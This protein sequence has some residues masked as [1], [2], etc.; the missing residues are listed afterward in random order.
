MRRAETPETLASEK[1]L[2]GAQIKAAVDLL[3]GVTAGTVAELNAIELLTSLGIASDRAKAMAAA[4]K[5][6]KVDTNIVKEQD[7]DKA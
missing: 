6:Q 5:G 4:A 7:D 3:A 1:G 2:N